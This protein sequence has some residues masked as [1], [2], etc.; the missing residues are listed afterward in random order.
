[1]WPLVRRHIG[2][3]AP[4]LIQKGVHHDVGIRDVELIGLAQHMPTIVDPESDHRANRPVI[5]E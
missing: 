3:C 2:G 5:G 1:M 4:Q